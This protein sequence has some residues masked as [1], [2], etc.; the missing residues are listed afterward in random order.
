M[1][2]GAVL[3]QPEAALVAGLVAEEEEVQVA[4]AAVEVEVEA[5]LVAL[6]PP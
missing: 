4:A 5:V 3:Y 2:A 1:R 6:L